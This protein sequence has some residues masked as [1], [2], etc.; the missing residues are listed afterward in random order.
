[1]DGRGLRPP[2]DIERDG[3]VGV[4]A[5]AADFKIGVSRIERVAERGRR[6][7]WPLEGEHALAPRLA[8]QLVGL[9]ARFSRALSRYSD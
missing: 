1:V 7:R 8:R 2:N 3:L 9:P 5:E 4:A 6:L